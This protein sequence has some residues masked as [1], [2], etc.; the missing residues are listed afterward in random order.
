MVG[1][2]LNTRHMIYQSLTK[3]CPCTPKRALI[4][5]FGPMLVRVIKCVCVCVCVCW[6]TG[7]S[8]EQ[9]TTI[10]P[11]KLIRCILFD[12]AALFEDSQWHILVYTCKHS[13]PRKGSIWVSALEGLHCTYHKRKLAEWSHDNHVTV[14]S[15]YLYSLHSLLQRYT[16]DSWAETAR[17]TS[18]IHHQESLNANQHIQERKNSQS[19]PTWPLSSRKG[20][21]LNQERIRTGD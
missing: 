14:C 2:A 4:P 10:P 19:M 17:L 16:L 21:R 12:N 3:K 15:S 7:W 11:F 6:G 20:T 18:S 5:N 8:S 1:T 13:Q 9:A